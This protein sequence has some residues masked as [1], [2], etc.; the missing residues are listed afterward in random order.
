MKRRGNSRVLV[1]GK[2][3]ERLRVGREVGDALHSVVDE[4]AVEVVELVLE[5]AGLES[6]RLDE[7]VLTPDGKTGD[8]DSGRPPD[9][10]GEAGE[11]ETPLPA[12]QGA[13]GQ[14][15]PGVDQEEG[16]VGVG[17]PRVRRHVDDQHPG[18]G[19]DLRGGEA[20]T[21]RVRAHGRKQVGSKDGDP[22]VDLRAR[23]GNPP[24]ERIG[25]E[26]LSWEA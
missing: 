6:P 26:W 7:D 22:G 23:P 1:A 9:A 8:N 20:D 3:L 21:A 16:S 2:L 4:H 10:G 15:D 18:E 17:S 19:A 25:D 14:D 12:G 5:D 13:G 24:E 11:G